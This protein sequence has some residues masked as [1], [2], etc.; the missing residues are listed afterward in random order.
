M[1]NPKWINYVSCCI[2]REKGLRKVALKYLDEFIKEAEIWEVEEKKDF[3]DFLFSLFET[4]PEADYVGFPKPLSDKLIKPI[5]I[6]WCNIEETNNN[7]FRWFGKYYRSEEHLSKALS[8]NSSDDKA[9]QTLISWWSYDIY[10]SVHHLPEYYIGDPYEDIK[11]SKK[12]KE[13]IQQLSTL[14]L[15]AYWEK[16]LEE[17]LELIKNY[18]DWKDSKHPDFEKWGKENKQK[19]GYEINRE[20]Y[21]E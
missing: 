9:R 6:A 11:L 16:E 17:D 4:I 19:T 3:V 14:D 21:C 8:L 7:P 12:I 2:E 13:Q 1:K 5:L 10:Y 20:Y 15:R 18:I